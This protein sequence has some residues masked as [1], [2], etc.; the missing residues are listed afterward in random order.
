MLPIRNPRFLRTATQSWVSVDDAAIRTAPQQHWLNAAMDVETK[1]VFDLMI[2][3]HR[4]T[5]L[6]AG[7]LGQ[8]AEKQNL[9]EV[10]FFVHGIGS[11]TALVD[12][13]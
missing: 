4:E 2:S 9:L 5:D 13:I 7:F 11:L 10:T 12:V 8:S 1:L 6:P 3:P